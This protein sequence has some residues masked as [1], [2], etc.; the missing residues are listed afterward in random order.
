MEA[1]TLQQPAAEALNFNDRRRSFGEFRPAGPERRQFQDARVSCNP[2]AM[3]LADAIDGYK[4]THRRRFITF[5]E[6][7]D[8]ISSLGYRKFE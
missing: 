2:D 4:L 6:L 7:H 8:V 3:E 5:E 1:A